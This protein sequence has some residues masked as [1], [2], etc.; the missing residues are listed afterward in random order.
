MLIICVVSS[1]T[2]FSTEINLRTGRLENSFSFLGR[3]G[4]FFSSPKHADCSDT[5]TVSY[6]TTIGWSF[7]RTKTYISSKP[8][9]NLSREDGHQSCI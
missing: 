4:D 9:K 1:G 5:P 7:F 3:G 8:K 2:L 6:S